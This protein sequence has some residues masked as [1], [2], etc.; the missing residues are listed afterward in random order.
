MKFSAILTRERRSVKRTKL[1]QSW[2]MNAPCSRETV[3][4]KST[5]WWTMCSK[6]V[7]ALMNQSARFVI[8]RHKVNSANSISVQLA[9]LFGA[10]LYACFEK[11]DTF[12]YHNMFSQRLGR[13][14]LFCENHIFSKLSWIACAHPLLNPYFWIVSSFYQGTILTRVKI[15]KNVLFEVRFVV[16][17]RCGMRRKCVK[18]MVR[19][20]FGCRCHS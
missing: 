3:W 9:G 20:T 8:F 15:L 14:F 5:F 18:R 4:E 13:L 6:S 10:P 17:M 16:V 1:D 2:S 7:W 12:R 11:V 19:N